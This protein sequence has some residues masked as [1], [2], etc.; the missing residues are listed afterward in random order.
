MGDFKKERDLNQQASRNDLNL[1]AQLKQ[2]EEE[3]RVYKKMTEALRA[4]AE[5]GINVLGNEMS[6]AK[7]GSNLA[8][9]LK[10]VVHGAKRMIGELEQDNLNLHKKVQKYMDQVAEQE[11]EISRLQQKS[12]V[13]TRGAQTDLEG[14]ELDEILEEVESQEAFYDENRKLKTELKRA[15]ES[16][17]ESQIEHQRVSSEMDVLMRRSQ[18]QQFASQSASIWNDQQSD[19]QVVSRL[20]AKITNMKMR[21]DELM[22]QLRQS[23][24]SHHQMT[25]G[26]YG[27][28]PSEP[29]ADLKAEERITEYEA[30][31]FEQRDHLLKLR[32][33]NSNLRHAL[34]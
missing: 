6:G 34:K 32:E 11:E 13:Q 14:D 8:E 12:R 19:E 21:E 5:D 4:A 17:K 7:E 16:L 33:E 24:A 26:K 30:V 10:R 22:D 18:Q 29:K 15:Q 2:V 25:P 3:G 27:K 28:Q 9:E 23:Q 31:I 1:V 20:Q